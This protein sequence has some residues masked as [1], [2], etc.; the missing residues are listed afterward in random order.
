MKFA[1]NKILGGVVAVPLALLVLAVVFF[2]TGSERDEEAAREAFS[3]FKGVDSMKVDAELVL[4]LPR[5][6]G[7][8]ERP[9][10]QV[11]S[12]V[13]GNMV[14]PFEEAP[15]FSGDLYVEAKGRGNIFFASGDLRVLEKDIM[16]YLDEMPVFLNPSGSLV[17]K[18]TRVEV[19]ALKTRNK[20]EMERVLAGLFS[21]LE[22]IGDEQDNNG[23]WVRFSGRIDEEWENKANRVFAREQSGNLALD[24]VS[25]LLESNNIKSLDVWVDKK[26]K[27]P[28]KMEAF[29]VRPLSNG[30]NF[31]FARLT[32][33]FS[34]YGKEVNVD[35]PE[36]Q[37]KV[38]ASVFGK[39]FGKGEI[40]EV[41]SDE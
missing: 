37:L 34:E 19:S 6:M 8:K 30:E 23:E 32:V 38:D 9:F 15:K 11:R 4:N 25:R 41:T 39:L 10:T 5:R 24:V 27:E 14:G 28:R 33:N 13:E 1:G 36:S 17:K 35:R 18:W 3:R 29:F 31:D 20:E 7:S 2:V 21:K 40:I 12:R 16:F 22:K 26:S